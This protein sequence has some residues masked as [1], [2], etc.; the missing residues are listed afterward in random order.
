M[1]E[2]LAKLSGTV[3]E[4]GQMSR[5]KSRRVVNASSSVDDYL[6]T[7]TSIYMYMILFILFAIKTIPEIYGF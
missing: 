1:V 6:L 3:R 7:L 5:R 2:L 4:E